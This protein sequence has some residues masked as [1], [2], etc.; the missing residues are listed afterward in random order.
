MAA[1]KWVGI[2]IMAE[3]GWGFSCLLPTKRDF[4]KTSWML[5]SIYLPLLLE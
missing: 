3:K 5:M 2:P 1:A 4:L